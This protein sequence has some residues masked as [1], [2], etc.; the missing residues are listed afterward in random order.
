M[1]QTLPANPGHETRT[2]ETK[3]AACMSGGSEYV[4]PTLGLAGDQ[5][6]L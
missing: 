3:M 5:G 4:K 2:R 6:Q 1:I